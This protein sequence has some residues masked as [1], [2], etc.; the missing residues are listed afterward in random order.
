MRS[1]TEVTYWRQG[2]QVGGPQV[3]NQITSDP[4]IT[5]A[6]DTIVAI[7]TALYAT[8]A[9]FG[10]AAIA[11]AVKAVGDALGGKNVTNARSAQV[12][13][14]QGGK[15][16]GLA[17][18]AD[19]ARILFRAW[20]D[21]DL[22][23]S[24]GRVDQTD[25]RVRV[26]DGGEFRYRNGDNN[27]YDHWFSMPLSTLPAGGYVFAFASGDDGWFFDVGVASALSVTITAIPVLTAVWAGSYVSRLLTLPKTSVAKTLQA[28]PRSV[29]SLMSFD[30]AKNVP[31]G[32]YGS[33]SAP[34]RPTGLGPPPRMVAGSWRP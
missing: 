17:Q 30:D 2:I 34:G 31:V 33:T 6:W 23:T 15:V 25:M 22:T 3:F 1:Y 24:F 5:D 10:I 20:S 9:S 8:Y 7:V 14:E 18:L 26:I 11:G 12:S 28:N 32:G 19:E 27:F 29:S 13:F 21:D 16:A 4:D